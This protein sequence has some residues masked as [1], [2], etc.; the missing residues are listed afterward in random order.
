MSKNERKKVLADLTSLN[1]KINEFEDK[2]KIIGEDLAY[3]IKKYIRSLDLER[4]EWCEQN[5]I[6]HDTFEKE[7]AEENI[8]SLKPYLSLI[9]TGKLKSSFLENKFEAINSKAIGLNKIFRSMETNDSEKI[10]TAISNYILMNYKNI[11][12]FCISM[13]D[14]GYNVKYSTFRTDKY[15]KGLN[16]ALKYARIIIDINKNDK[17]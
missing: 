9:L 16:T 15:N 4:K 5:K 10:W 13:T 11:Q 7:L 3:M 12:N 8:I 2:L 1:D 14:K 17:K 6:N